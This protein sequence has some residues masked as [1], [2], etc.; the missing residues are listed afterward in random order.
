MSEN[1]DRLLS[2]AGVLLIA[3]GAIAAFAGGSYGLVEQS[4]GLVI[5]CVLLLMGYG[6]V[7]YL[8]MNRGA[9][10]FHFVMP[11]TGVL[12]VATLLLFQVGM[13]DI[14]GDGFLQYVL[15]PALVLLLAF[16]AGA[17]L[18]HTIEEMTPRVA[19]PARGTRS[20]NTLLHVA[21]YPPIFGAFT[22]LDL[23]RSPSTWAGI[24][25]VG[26]SAAVAIACVVGGYASARGSHPAFTVV[27]GALGFLGSAAYLFQFMSAQTFRGEAAYGELNA[28]IGLIVSSLP[29][30]IAAVAWIQVNARDDDAAIEKSADVAP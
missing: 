5:L 29:V 26:A 30:A 9:R 4:A 27:G 8:L 24:F 7:G 28:L 12:V 3:A 15:K 1:G 17:L 2:N 25:I 11:A 21:A 18:T 6:V 13:E 19:W 14:L 20:L 23:I 10:D 16:A 22:L